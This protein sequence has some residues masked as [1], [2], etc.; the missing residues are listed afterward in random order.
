MMIARK[1]LYL[2]ALAREKHFGR[3][4]AAC[5]ISPSTL[6]AAISDLE[7]ELG[8]AVVERGKHFT[9]LTPEGQ[10][11]VDYAHRMAAAEE[12]MRQELDRL[13]HGL[14]GHLRLG[15]IP[16]A[17]TVVASLTSALSRR[18][19]LVTIEVLSLSTSEILARMQDFELD[20]GIVYVES[21]QAVRQLLTV[22]LWN[23]SHVLLTPSGSPFEGRDSV[24]WLE[25]VKVPLCLLTPDMQNRKTIDA[26]FAGLDC[27]VLP[28]VET[29]SIVSML[30]HV[31]S[32]AWS[33]I[34]PHSVLDLIGIPEGVRV[35][36]LVE[37]AVA[38]TTG[39]VVPQREPRPPMIE[40][41][42]AEAH[43]LNDSFAKDE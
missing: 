27:K 19:P 42:L 13:R 10:C 30:A 43:Y 5:H 32:G 22:P 41:L 39:L 36:P 15:V 38:W 26:V 25:A 8:V 28:T 21:G 1:Y 20:A 23:E 7:A 33:S 34:M 35:L 6:S 17:L 14:S 40:A 31:C 24:T 29:N 4:A 11:V 2:I 18:Y 3:A 9:G 12:G 16:T 37:P